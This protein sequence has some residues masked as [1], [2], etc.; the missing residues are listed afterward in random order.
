MEINTYYS[1]I[2]PV[3][4]ER[5]YNAVGVRDCLDPY[6][7]RDLILI[8]EGGGRIT[9]KDIKPRG[10]EC[11]IGVLRHHLDSQFTKGPDGQWRNK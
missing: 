1:D 5:P 6:T 2:G 3:Q 9:L 11:L 10:L 8:V 4:L 7:G